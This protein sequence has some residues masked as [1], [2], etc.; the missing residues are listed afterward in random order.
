MSSLDDKVR[1]AAAKLHDAIREATA[2]GYKVSWP[3]RPSE[4]PSILVSE[5]RA[6]QPGSPTQIDEPKP[7]PKA[8]PKKSE[9]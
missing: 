3:I 6:N 8:A 1:Q 7:A 5:T 9:G 4:L 2:A